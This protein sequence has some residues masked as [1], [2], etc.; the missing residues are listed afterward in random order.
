M[1]AILTKYLSGI[2]NLSS[3]TFIILFLVFILL[4]IVKKLGLID[5]A[6]RTIG[7]LIKWLGLKSNSAAPL[8]T[9]IVL[10]IIYGAGIIDDLI[11]EQNISPRQVFLIAVFLGICHALFEDTGLFLAIGANLFWITIPR[12][13]VA[14]FVTYLA[15]KIYNE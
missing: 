5:R 1:T 8:L 11:K 6:D 3:K 4:E 2:F 13:V 10:G 7:K 15:S 12:I 9:G 14:I